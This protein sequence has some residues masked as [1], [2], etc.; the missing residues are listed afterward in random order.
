MADQTHR[1][2]DPPPVPAGRSDEPKKK[3]WWPTCLIGCF[4][5]FVLILVGGG[6]GIWVL[7]KK[8]PAMFAEIA[9]TGLTSAVNESDLPAEEKQQVVAQIDRLV[10]GFKSGEITGEELGTA[11]QK[12][13]E[14]PVMAGFI[15]AG[16][17]A[18]Y[19][20]NAT[21]PDEEKASANRALERLWRGSDEGKITMNDL[22]PLLN[23]VATKTG[24]S[25]QMK[26]KL[27]DEE[28]KQFVAKS[29]EIADTAAIPDEAYPIKISATLKKFVDEIFQ[30]VSPEA[31]DVQIPGEA[32]APEVESD[33]DV[34]SGSGGDSETL[35]ESDSTEP[36]EAK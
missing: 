29:S 10:D 9:R 22:E 27:S 19:V 5:M 28:V 23:I 1:F 11:M 25:W 34:D 17:K 36:A 14:S 33:A 15:V 26:P 12:V 4:V 8:G 13:M 30:E 31:A 35:D 6:I 16:F 2:G 20:D 7:T 32:S 24:N 21:W 18:Q 3:S